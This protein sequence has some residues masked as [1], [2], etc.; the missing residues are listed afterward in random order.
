VAWENVP[1]SPVAGTTY[2][3]GFLLPAKT[4]SS[5]LAGAHRA[6]TGVYQVSVVAPL[7]GGPGIAEGIADEIAALFPLNTRLAVPGLILQV[8]TPV[9]AAQGAQDSTS[10]IVP[11]SFEYRADIVS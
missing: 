6:F 1:Y 4:A 9:T 11:V 7:N 2:L 10:Y 5:D 3:R 8:V